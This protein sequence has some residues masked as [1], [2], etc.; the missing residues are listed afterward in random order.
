[1][2][3][4]SHLTDLKIFVTEIGYKN[5]NNNNSSNITGYRGK[6]T[7]ITINTPLAQQ[8]TILMSQL[9]TEKL[10]VTLVFAL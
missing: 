1:L 7:L 4:F 5:K 10:A 2:D 3:D 8:G 9:R 6:R